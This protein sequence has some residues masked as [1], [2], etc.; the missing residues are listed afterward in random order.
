M[1]ASFKS[2]FSDQLYITRSKPHYLEILNRKATKGQGLRAVCDYFGIDC[3]EVMA[4]GD[5]YNDIEMLKVAG[6]AVVVENAPSAVKEFAHHITAS[7]DRDGVALALQ[8]LI[9]EA[10]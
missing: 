7:N 9:L 6:T 10:E 1:E 3:R 8:H 5:S 2:F 4:I